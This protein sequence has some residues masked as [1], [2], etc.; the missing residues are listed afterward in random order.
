MSAFA[1]LGIVF[2]GVG[3]LLNG[4]EDKQV[5]RESPACRSPP[6]DTR[7]VKP[8]SW[9]NPSDRVGK[10]R[11]LKGQNRDEDSRAR[12]KKRFFVIMLRNNHPHK[13]GLNH[14]TK[15]LEIEKLKG[16]VKNTGKTFWGTGPVA[17][18]LSSHAPLQAAQG[19]TSL[20]PG[21]GHGTAHQAMLRR[22]PTCHN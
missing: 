21:R 14:W 19:F 9:T 18:R 17:E 1:I 13:N 6:T 4:T 16:K 5:A 15:R 10:T 22:H 7:H 12:R 20:N 8:R 11:S 2:K 3:K